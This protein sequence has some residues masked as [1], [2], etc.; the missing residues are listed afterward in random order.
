MKKRRSSP[1]L[2]KY[3]HY[4]INRRFSLTG[5]KMKFTFQDVLM[6]HR[7]AAD[8]REHGYKSGADACDELAN[9]IAEGVPYEERPE[10]KV[11]G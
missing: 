4:E 7:S 11:N 1:V 6:L 9:R 10:P 3:L 2:S 5:A 8:L